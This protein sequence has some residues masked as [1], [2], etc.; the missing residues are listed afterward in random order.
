M[1]IVWKYLGMLFLNGILISLDDCLYVCEWCDDCF[2]VFLILFVVEIDGK[3]K[4]EKFFGWMRKLL[5]VNGME[6]KSWDKVRMDIL[7][8]VFWR[9]WFLKLR[10]VEYWIYFWW[11]RLVKNLYRMNSVKWRYVYFM[12]YV[13]IY[14]SWFYFNSLLMSWVN[15]SFDFMGVL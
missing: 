15:V 2:E 10:C 9:I 3:N 12:E 8:W 14:M 11:Y 1:F 6:K 5:W 7:I 4:K 13:R